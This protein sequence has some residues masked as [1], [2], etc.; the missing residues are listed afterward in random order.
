MGVAMA[1][2]QSVI[3]NDADFVTR[4]ND[5]DGVAYAVQKFVMHSVH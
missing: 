5:N 3:K 2:A 4:S 1:N